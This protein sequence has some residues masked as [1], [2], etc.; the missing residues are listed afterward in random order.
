MIR[1]G[2]PFIF[3]V[4]TYLGLLIEI[5]L[6]HTGLWFISCTFT[7]AVYFVLHI[8]RN[9]KTYAIEFLFS[10]VLLIAGLS[11]AFQLPWLRIVYFPFVISLTAFYGLTTIIPLS[12]MLPLLEVRSFIAMGREQLPGEVAFVASLIVTAS[13]ASFL[14]ST[15]KKD[16]RVKPSS[17]EAQKVPYFASG[18][19]ETPMSDEEVMSHYQTSVLRS[20]EEIR[21]ILM[22]AK[23]AV[24]SDSVNLFVKSGS[25]LALRC[26]TEESG[27]IIF[28]GE[29]LISQC[30][31]TK[32]TIIASDISEKK[33]D[34]GYIKKEK[35]SSF[36]AVPVFDGEIALGV[37]AAD[38]ARFSAFS[39]AE[40]TTLQMF[41]KQLMRII[42]RERV[43]PQIYRS[44]AGLKILH[45]ESSKL[46]S[47]LNVEV[48]SQKLIEGAYRIAP[49]EIIFFIS[50][51][52]AFEV[53]HRVGIP[54]QE[55]Q[56]FSM[57]DTLLDMVVRNREPLY[58]SDVRNYPLA[59]MPFKTG[60]VNSVFVLP[61]LYEKDLIG[62]LAFLSD[63][64]NALTPYQ[65]R[66]L[67]VLANQAA[68]SITN[69]RL[70]TEIEKLA[71]TDGLTGLFNHRHFQEMLSQEFN[72]LNRLPDHF[73]LLMIDLD[74]FKKVND[75]YGH[76]VGD[77]TLKGV[78]NIIRATIR[79]IDIPARYGGEEFAV[80]LVGTD[81]QGAKHT[82]ERLRKTIMDTAFS[83]EGKT[84][85][86]T[87]SIGISTSRGAATKEDMLERADQALY[88]AKE[89]G[90]NSCVLWGTSRI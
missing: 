27:E 90:R 89:S 45:E 53:I 12:L 86:V 71:I 43:Y 18:A 64:T 35:I 14:L 83:A 38:S 56:S 9:D 57:K 34:L 65:M 85:K 20:D 2:V 63:K 78:A 47:S 66:L 26:S 19:E 23:N 76:L 22:T 59:I 48:I 73:S 16:K 37:L 70:Y 87:V 42:Q 52:E 60:K 29:G 8:L 81:A 40:S 17:L 84:F 41:S 68:T 74:H 28:S 75:T 33:T 46:L 13:I 10:L 79:N 61:L 31:I 3:L 80:I 32:E 72:R 24:F 82:A 50:K 77:S 58:L 62:I 7:I 4:L 30:L 88:Q 15:F 21:E 1:R 39:A 25:G 44:H 69:A 51:G 5:P 67:E 36:V 54:S 6:K 49:L 55:R 11:Q